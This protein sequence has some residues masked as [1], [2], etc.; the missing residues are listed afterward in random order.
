VLV[1]QAEGSSNS[2]GMRSARR[3]GTVS[4]ENMTTRRH[5]PDRHQIVLL[6]NGVSHLLTEFDVKP[7][8]HR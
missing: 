1:V 4:F 7:D 5:D 2:E 8:W 3:L 6:I